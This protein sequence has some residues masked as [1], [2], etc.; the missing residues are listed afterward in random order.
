[1]LTICPEC[2]LKIK[3]PVRK[4][5]QTFFCP[6]CDTELELIDFNDLETVV[7]YAEED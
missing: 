6:E 1:M 5:G 2:E 7:D 4:V 3:C